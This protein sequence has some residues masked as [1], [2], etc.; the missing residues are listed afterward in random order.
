MK[1]KK[2]LAFIVLFTGI[3]FVSG[4]VLPA[5]FE[6]SKGGDKKVAL[7][8]SGDRIPYSQISL[9][10]LGPIKVKY[11][12]KGVRKVSKAPAP[13]QHP[14]MLH[15]PSDRKMLLDIYQGTEQGQ[16]LW[17]MLEGYTNKLKGKIENRNEY[18]KHPNGKPLAAYQRGGWDKQIHNR[19]KEIIGGKYEDKR[20][21]MNDEMFS[22]M[23]LEAFR[24]WVMNDRDAAKEY[25]KAT[26]VIVDQLL[27]HIK[28]G[29]HCSFISAHNMGFIY[30]YGHPFMSKTLRNKVRTLIARVSVNAAHYGT[31]V[32]AVA[33]TSNWVT[34][35]SFQAFTLAAI[36][37]E[38]GFNKDYFKGFKRAYH[39]FITYGFYASG[40]G[41][42]GL[43]KNY[44]FNATM[45]LLAKRGMNLI[46]H[47]HVHAY[48]KNFLPAISLPHGNGF[49]A[50]DDW[51]GTGLDEIKGDYRFSVIDVIG[52]KW[53]YPTD[54]GVDY[55]WRS[56]F[57][58]NYERYTDV[59]SAGYY[60]TALFMIGFPSQPL[61]KAPSVQE[62]GIKLNHFFPERGY[63]ISRSDLTKDSLFLTHHCRQD[64]GGHTS[65][66]RNHF[67][68][69]SHERLWG[70]SLTVAGGSKFGKVNESRF[71]STVLI[72]NKGQCGM[73]TGCFPVPGKVTSQ[74]DSKL[75]S[76]MTG[77]ASYAYSWE[78]H[79]R[80][81]EVGKESP[82]LKK[83]WEKVLETP[84]DF[85]YQ[86]IKGRPHMNQA[87]Y[88]KPHWL[89][90]GKIQHYVKRPYNTVQKAKRIT[91][92]VRGKSPYV[93]IADDIQK[94]ELTHE[95]KWIMQAASDLEI[96]KYHFTKDSDIHDIYLCGSEVKRN[97]A[98]KRVPKKG[99][100]VLLVRVLQNETE[101]HWD[102]PIGRLEQYMD[103]IRRPQK[104]GKRLVIT[105]TSVAPKFKVMLYPH[106]HGDPIPETKW[107]QNGEQ[108]GIKIG[109]QVDTVSF[110]TGDT[111][112]QLQIIR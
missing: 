85:Q 65:A 39:N 33:T 50:T 78:W 10:D 67:V 87:F 110:F 36:E 16:L 13:G 38:E 102:T 21:N 52:L 4:Q 34:L 74:H 1:M 26:E 48:A 91:A 14:R 71:F 53:M 108:L 40:C 72:D 83:G 68:F 15:S 70:R 37:G 77:D 84:N 49:V 17:K 93:L 51:G 30:D 43:G 18:P 54:P 107:A 106:L 103:N 101:N 111:K 95:Y 55:V 2:R 76:S 42:E 64:N 104:A 35:D 80:K 92:M 46:G 94:D 99:D 112:D 86:P 98:D 9:S 8:K 22:I 47:P 3:G 61:E 88:E 44:Q 5:G 97:E 57:G 109:A 28:E 58:E 60:N 6:K 12:M 19:Y 29:D 24:C 7:T 25:L 96:V 59:R 69:A 62:A 56:Y 63:Q 105:S 31:F 27:K 81:G 82:M 66:D 23:V 75:F 79:W 73:A 20:L 90:P 100:P 41:Y 32:D 11:S 89:S 45:V